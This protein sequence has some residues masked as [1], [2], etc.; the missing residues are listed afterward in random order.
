MPSFAEL[1]T[2]GHRSPFE[3]AVYRDHQILLAP[4]ATLKKTPDLPAILRHECAHAWLRAAGV[5]PLP[6]LLEETVAM[7]LAGQSGR[8]PPAAALDVEGQAHAARQAAHPKDRQA[9]EHA[10]AAA[11][12][13][14]GP[15][16]LEA[17]KEHRLLAA[18]K[19][20]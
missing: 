13:T 9:L 16:L 8:L 12:A 14:F 19:D 3:V 17:I 2:K 10:L 11:H 6:I 5:R 1:L 18:L 15:R 20:P 4:P 7:L